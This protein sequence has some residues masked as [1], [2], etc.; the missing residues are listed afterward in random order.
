[1]S[2][3]VVVSSAQARRPQAAT[4]LLIDV[5][6]INTLRP[7]AMPQVCLGLEGYRN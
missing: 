2:C 3:L 5:K 1:M 7:T 6:D 4:R